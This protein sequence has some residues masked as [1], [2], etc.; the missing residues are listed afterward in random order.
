MKFADKCI[1]YVT[2]NFICLFHQYH[3]CGESNR[4]YSN[5]YPTRCNVTHS[6][7]AYKSQQ[8][9]HVTEFTFV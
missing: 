2:P 4:R 6:F 7:V 8:D 1:I 3:K 5:I 9:P